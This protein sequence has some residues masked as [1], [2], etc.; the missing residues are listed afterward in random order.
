MPCLDSQIWGTRQNVSDDGGEFNNDLFVN[1]AELFNHSLKPTA[2][3]S[4]WSNSMA[5]KHSTI[6][7]WTME[8][9]VLD[10]SN[11]YPINITAAWAVMSKIICITAVVLAQNS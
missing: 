6:I 10:Q 3:E 9:L 7:G 5:E 1:V 8:K 4:P 11:K 2:A